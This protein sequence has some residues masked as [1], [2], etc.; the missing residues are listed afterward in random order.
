M[1]DFTD[2]IWFRIFVHLRYR[3]LAVFS[4]VCRRFRNVVDRENVWEYQFRKTWWPREAEDYPPLLKNARDNI[5]E[6]IIHIRTIL[7]N[8]PTM[9]LFLFKKKN[10]EGQI[11]GN[12]R[13]FKIRLQRPSSQ[14]TSQI[15]MHNQLYKPF[16]VTIFLPDGRE[17]VFCSTVLKRY[18][19]PIYYLIGIEYA[20]HDLGSLILKWRVFP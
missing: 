20:V 9:T 19:R 18:A 14:L 16:K 11:Y 2:S 17:E 13:H 10:R 8:D 5:R 7:D 15:S 6:R 1:D 12:T 3:D 4:Q